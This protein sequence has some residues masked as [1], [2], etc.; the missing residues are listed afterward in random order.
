M[1]TFKEKSYFS[2]KKEPKNT[3]LQVRILLDD[4]PAG[5]A[6]GLSARPAAMPLQSFGTSALQCFSRKGQHKFWNF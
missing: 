1:F 5:A 2:R 3:F 6:T 4:I